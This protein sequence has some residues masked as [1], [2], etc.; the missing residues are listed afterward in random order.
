MA[1]TALFI[2]AHP[3]DIEIGAG[4]TVAKLVGRDWDVWF[5]IMTKE[6]GKAGQDRQ[7]EA[8]SAAN[9]LGIK[10]DHVIFA[11][12]RDAYLV[13][14]QESISRVRQIVADYSI[15]PDVVFTHTNSDSHNDHRA[16]YEITVSALRQV[17]ILC[18]AVINSFI[19]TNFT[20][21]I[22]VDVENYWPTKMSS[23]NF[24]RSQSTRINEPAM[25]AHCESYYQQTGI[26]CAEGFQFFTPMG[27][28]QQSVYVMRFNDS[29]FHQFW[30][31]LIQER[32]MFLIYAIPVQRKNLDYIWPIDRD[33]EGIS[34]LYNRFNESWNRLSRTLPIRDVSSDHPHAES[35]LQTS[36][37][38]LSGG[39]VSNVITRNHF[40]HFPGIRYAIDYVMPD[41][42]NI[43]IF[44][45]KKQ[46]RIKARYYMDDLGNTLVRTDVGI[47]TIMKNPYMRD[48]HIVAVMG[49]HGFGT[50]G[51]YKV[52]SDPVNLAHLLEL[53]DVP[54]EVDGFQ[55]LVEYDVASGIPSLLQGSLHEVK[56]TGG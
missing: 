2:G 28:D 14:N 34:R 22:F 51:C 31:P 36:D 26:K 18:Y 3:D 40:N 52:L 16:T 32:Q 12:Y 47:L 41:Y 8:L 48:R 46:E 15:K 24:H 53:I 50:L 23:L 21:Y 10:K 4:G 11:D 7:Q 1:P 25:R 20:P 19:T 29:K 45:R 33:R 49:I 39:A 17:P 56:L 27:S 37:I 38:L 54:L 30:Y 42:R 44:D 43:S 9:S 13:C 5:L 35:I 6:A 55:I